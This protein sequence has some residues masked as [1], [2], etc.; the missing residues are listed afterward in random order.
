[1]RLKTPAAK[2]ASGCLQ[3]DKKIRLPARGWR[4]GGISMKPYFFIYHCPHCHKSLQS[5]NTESGKTLSC[6]GCQSVFTVPPPPARPLG[7]WLQFYE[8]G[9]LFGYALIL[10]CVVAGFFMVG[11]VEFLVFIPISTIPIIY[12]YG[13]HKQR[14]WFVRAAI[15]LH[16]ISLLLN[17]LLL[18]AYGFFD[19]AWIIYFG[20]S[21]RVK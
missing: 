2:C 16:F 4:V 14:K 8:F 13:L 1:M 18:S 20:R 7:G 5:Q 11:W 6:P 10:A 9:V 3:E 15:T 19:L 12:I 17:V 21:Q